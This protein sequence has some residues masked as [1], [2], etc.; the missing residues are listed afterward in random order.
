M[1]QGLVEPSV[2]IEVE[3][4]RKDKV[5]NT[6]IHDKP[7]HSVGGWGVGGGDSCCPAASCDWLSPSALWQGGRVPG[8]MTSLSAF[9]RQRETKSNGT[10]IF[11]RKRSGCPHG[12]L[13]GPLPGANG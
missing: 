3:E 13:E 7:T 2:T 6:R 8:E 5:K 10:I 4:R 11:C 1:E 12:W 9:K